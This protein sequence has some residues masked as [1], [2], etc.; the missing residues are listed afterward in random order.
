MASK[1]RAQRLY[2]SNGRL[3]MD[4][5]LNK[6]YARALIAE[7]ESP[8]CLN[9]VFENGA[10]KSRP[11]I[12][13]LNTTSVG[14]YACNGLYVRHDSDGAQSLCAWFGTDMFVFNGTSFTT[15]PSAQSQYT[16]GVRVAA[17][18]YENYLFVGNG[19]VGPYKYADSGFTRHGIPAPTA[20][21]TAATKSAG[22]LTGDYR[23]K[24]TYVN[25]GLVESDV[26]PVTATFT[27]A[28]EEIRWSDIPV[29]PVSFGVTSR[30]LYRTEAGGT[31]FKRLATLN[32]NTTTIYDD[33][34]SDSE[35]GVTAP[36]DQGEP[37]QYSA[38]LYHNNRLFMND[39]A[40]PNFVWYSEIAN[41]YVVKST[42]FR[43]LGDNTTDIVRGF[44][45][46][47]NHVLVICDRSEF[48][49]YMPD[50]DDS[51]WS[52][53]RI[54]S[55]YGS[56]SPFGLVEY[57]NKVLFP[58]MQSD[59]FVGF[60]AVYGTSIDPSATLLTVAATGSDLK[61][62]RIEPDMFLI[63]E[64][65]VQNISAIVYKNKA[66]ITVPY[67]SGQTTNNRVYVFDFSISNL[68]RKQ[69]AAWSPFDGIHA[70]QFAIFNGNVYYGTS[71]DTGYVYQML[72]GV[73][74][75]DSAA[76]DSYYWT[77]EFSGLK[78]DEKYTKDWRYLQ[79][80][81]KKSGNFYMDVTYRT[82][83]DQGTGDTARIYLGAGGSSWGAFTWGVDD[84]DAGQAEGEIELPLGQ[85][86]GKRLQIKFSNQ[87]TANQ[88]FEVLGML[89]GYNIKGRR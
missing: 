67:G 40:N 1:G 34:S 65:Q 51:N 77:K 47:E 41:P 68:Q 78:G 74:N 8:D 43:R 12:A 25:S 46:Y 20:T 62:E 57:N 16:A 37:P 29:A 58:A 85:A 33:N 79:V 64:N 54:K 27:A 31:T 19:T 55:S 24:V 69:E 49:I 23:L 53:I 14:S 6:K 60:A 10:V 61:S 81:Y 32:D 11:G 71:D 80:F 13:K 72:A 88:K 39:P 89:I 86:R 50:S 42:N 2:P 9:V 45:R 84:W 5:G 15:V 17:A 59:K 44:Q 87:N 66:Y 76:I 70:A 73:D 36:T 30:R 35:L 63:P 18:E 26:G 38:I 28:A 83:S 3:P 22:T 82:D 7:N 75:D 56:K 52:D 48:L 4:G 21:S